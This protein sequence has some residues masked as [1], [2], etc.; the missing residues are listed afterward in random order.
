M[1]K[2]IIL[3]LTVVTMIMPTVVRAEQGKN[4]GGSEATFSL[5]S[6]SIE[7]DEKS[8]ELDREI[9]LTFSKNVNNITVIEENKNCFDIV[10][11]EGNSVL[12]EVITFDDQLDKDNRNNIVLDAQLEANTDYIIEI[13][14]AVTSKSGQSLESDIEIPFTTANGVAESNPSKTDE[15]ENAGGTGKGDES[16]SGDGTGKGDG[17]GSGDKAGKG[18]GSG[19]GDQAGQND[20]SIIEDEA[21]KDDETVGGDKEA[22]SQENVESQS[23]TDD[24]DSSTEDKSPMTS[25]VVALIGAVAAVVLIGL[26][27]KKKK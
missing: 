15:T 4:G 8:V 24:K 1:R 3:L 17:S 18:D 9:K 7:K 13:D 12:T 26:V 6:S 5:S 16:G 11:A 2:K 23:N 19:S 25:T 21:N 14:K 27:I 20:E 10:D 22:T